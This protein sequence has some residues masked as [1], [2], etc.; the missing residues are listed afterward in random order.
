MKP[1]KSLAA[2]LSLVARLSALGLP[3]RHADASINPMSLGAVY[4]AGQTQI[5]F[6]VYSSEA[7]H[8]VLYLYS[9]GYGV[10]ESA[11]Y[12]LTNEGGGVW[13]VIVPVASIQAAGITGAVYYG[14][15]VWGPNWTYSSSWSKGSAVGFVSDV[16][17]LHA[18]PVHDFT[19]CRSN[20]S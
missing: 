13:Q 17:V 19:R 7:T 18:M 10:Q 4:N 15:R 8:M 12:T 14:Y 3:V 11:T 20:I 1:L 16:C 6:R 5:T 9:A 2:C